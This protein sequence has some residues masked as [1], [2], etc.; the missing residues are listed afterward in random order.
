MGGCCSCF[1]G[2]RGGNGAANDGKSTEMTGRN[3]ASGVPP[4][5]HGL[6][7]AMSAPTIKIRGFEVSGSGL[8]LSNVPVEQDVV[9][10]V[11]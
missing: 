4:A 3:S 9:D 10:N 8:A 1:D 5:T 6:S 11:K 2:I 7:R